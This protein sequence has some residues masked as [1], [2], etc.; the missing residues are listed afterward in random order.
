MQTWNQMF[1]LLTFNCDLDIGLEW[2]HTVSI[3]WIFDLSYDENPSGIRAG[4]QMFK[5]VTLNCVFM[6]F[7]YAL[8]ELDIS[9]TFYE[10]IP[11]VK[12]VGCRHWIKGSNFWSLRVTMILESWLNYTHRK[13]SINLDK[14]IRPKNMG[15]TWNSMFNHIIFNCELDCDLTIKKLNLKKGI[16]YLW[17]GHNKQKD[18]NKCKNDT[19]FMPINF[20]NSNHKILVTLR[21]H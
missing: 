6:K 21:H 4:I 12:G 2:M 13:S 20:I 9:P 14:Y 15:R 11:G 18:K 3:R 10:I 5:L 1:K 8:T 16:K 17:N 7:A 19:K